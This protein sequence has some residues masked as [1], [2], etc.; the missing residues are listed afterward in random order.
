M[1]GGGMV[2]KKKK[3]ETHN[4]SV[5]IDDDNIVIGVTGTTRNVDPHP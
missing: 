4:A 2:I 3:V 1:K 5:G